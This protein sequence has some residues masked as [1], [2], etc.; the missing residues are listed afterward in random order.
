MKRNVYLAI[1]VWVFLLAL[2]F[3]LPPQ[4]VQAQTKKQI[5][6][7]KKLITEGDNLYRLKSYR[8]AIEKYQAA[9]ELLPNNPAAYFSK[10]CAHYY[11]NEYDLALS[12]LN[13][14]ATQGY[15]SAEISKIRWNIYY[16]KK[17]YDN[18]L[19]DIQEVINNG[20]AAN[21]DIYIAAGDI[22]REKNLDKEAFEAYTKASELDPNN[23]DAQ[24]F[25]AVFNAKSGQSEAQAMAALNAARKGTKYQAESWYLAGDGLQKTKKF[26]ESA[27]AYER[28]IA[29]KSTNVDAYKNLSQVYQALNQYDKAL[30]TVK[31]GIAANPEDAGLYIELSGLHTIANRNVD[32]IIA[33]KQA[34]R[35]APTQYIGYSKLCRAYAD[36][37]Q[38]QLATD[39]CT[40]SLELNPGDGESTFY[41]ARAYDFQKQTN[42]ATDYY[43][44]AVVGLSEMAKSNPDYAD[45]YYL[46]GNAY[47][48]VGENPNA[49][50]AYKKCLELSPK[51]TRAMYNLGLM[52][53]LSGDKSSARAQYDSLLKIDTDLAGKLLKDI[54]G[55]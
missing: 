38:Y 8:G 3:V 45:G 9:V 6:A 51:Y 20:N 10:G 21:A 30:T 11:L 43:K 27:E 33:A 26:A 36:T 17:D 4:N 40:K 53:A 15:N 47:Y 34:I 25:I 2:G 54:E 37:K 52:Y 49:I 55:K 7:A 42:K 24:Y 19:K 48:A 35:I 23:A 29:A 12:D 22:Y 41:L 14:A 28:A 1:S 18:A 44:K 46:L 13:L 39:T 31:K 50:N 32:A 16:S 5:A